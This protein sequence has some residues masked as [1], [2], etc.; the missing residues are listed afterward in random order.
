MVPILGAL[1]LQAAYG[2][3]DI[4]IVGKF[5]TT[6]GISAPAATVFGITINLIYYAHFRKTITVTD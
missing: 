6:S 4:L 5:G 3:A 1:I 2:A